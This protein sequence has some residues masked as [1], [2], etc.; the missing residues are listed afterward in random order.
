MQSLTL[1]DVGDIVCVINGQKKWFKSS[2]ITAEQKTDA[3]GVV[4]YV[5]KTLRKVYIVGNGNTTSKQWSCVADY[6]ITSIPSASGDYAVTLNSTAQG[7]FTYTKT[8]GTKEE[9][10]TQLEAWLAAQGAS[11]KAAKWEARYDSATGK[12]YLQQWKY[13]EYESTVTIAGC[14]LSKKI[15]IEISANATIYNSVAANQYSGMC[16]DRLYNY[17][18]NSTSTYCNPT[19]RMNGTTQLFVTYPC[20]KTYYDG[21][22]GDGLRANYSTYDLYLDACMIDLINRRGI[23]LPQYDG[24]TQTAALAAKTIVK[25]VTTRGNVQTL[26]AYS[27]ADYAYNYT[28]NREGFLAHD[29][30][31]P[32]MFELAQLMQPIKENQTDMVNVSL[33][34]LGWTKIAPTSNRWSS[35]RCYT[36]LAWYYDIYGF[37]YL[38]SFYYSYSCS[39]VSAFTI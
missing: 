19:T 24:K 22:L 7:N 11:T 26:P 38:G 8:T 35:C 37:S 28:S 10:V 6:E 9:F 39:V 13:D 16:R 2:E 29:W 14:S 33:G 25:S 4:F 30:W 34:V 1:P 18:V 5:D 12:A 20:S 3:V 27:A 17:C 32:D 31:L 36:N 15:G 23:L 21:E